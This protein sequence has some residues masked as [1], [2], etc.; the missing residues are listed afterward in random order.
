MFEQVRL[1]DGTAA[2]VLPLEKT[3]KAQLAA[4]YETL[5]PETKRLRFLSPVLHLSG[6]LL[7]HLVDEVDG[8]NHVALVLCAETQPDVFDPVALARLVRYPDVPDAADLAVT[9]RDEWQGRGVATELLKVLMRH[10]P[11]GVTRIVTEVYRDN[12]ASLAMLHEL[13][14]TTVADVG[15]GVLEV[16]VDLTP[17]AAGVGGRPDGLDGCGGV[18]PAGPDDLRSPV[19]TMARPSRRGPRPE[20]DPERRRRLRTRDQGHP[21]L[22]RSRHE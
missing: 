11:A 9:V 14:P 13:G 6:A 3:D 5:S 15:A 17:V 18:E 16:E 21:W 4:E 19:L 1:R 22:T 7:A 2:W 20:P 10:R 12:P 8:L